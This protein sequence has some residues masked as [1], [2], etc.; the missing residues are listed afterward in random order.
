MPILA[1]IFAVALV[2]LVAIAAVHQW[3]RADP[4]VRD[5][6]ALSGDPAQ[7]EVIFQLNCAVCHGI[8]AQGL[9][10]PNLFHVASRKSRVGLIKQVISGKTPPMPQ[11]QPDPE[12]MADLLE[13]LETL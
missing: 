11:F 7:G 3:Q 5:V 8:D 6:L 13:Y 2:V 1:A 10:G 9:V 12:T 4:Y